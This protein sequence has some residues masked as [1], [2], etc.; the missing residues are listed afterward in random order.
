MKKRVLAILCVLVLSL[1]LFVQSSAASG[2]L[3][4][5]SLN[6]TLPT[7]TLQTTP[8]EYGGWIYVPTTVFNSRVTG[9]HFSIYYGLTEENES[10]IFY[11]LSGK[12]LTFN[13]EE[14]TA[15]T[16]SGERPVPASVLRQNGIYY[17]PVYPICR[18]FGLGYAYYNTEYGPLLRIKDQNVVLSD[19]LFLSSIGDLMRSRINAYYA[20]NNPPTPPPTTTTT[21]SVPPPTPIPEVPETPASPPVFPLSVGLRATAKTDVTGSLNALG[22]V[23]AS[24]VV[25]FPADAVADCTQQLRQVAGR[26]HQVGLIPTG[27]SAQERQNSVETGR[28][29]VAR[30]LRQETWFV[31]GQD[32]ALSDAGYLCWQPTLS[33]SARKDVTDLYTTIIE[34]AESQNGRYR[35][36]LEADTPIA[37]L[38]GV[39]NQLKKDGD[40]FRSTR[41]T[42]Y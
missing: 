30:I 39:L 35:V 34:T 9:T 25:F 24:A 8:I 21:P 32:K 38:S 18:H 40:T 11:N 4:F 33:L 5:L 41:E 13:L 15:V 7:N 29:L 36:L 31:L 19:S 20:Q 14:G 28:A 2:Q 37:T 27:N 6:D 22:A 42:E 16:E 17:V 23:S 1:P 12:T 26:G 10:L 3:F